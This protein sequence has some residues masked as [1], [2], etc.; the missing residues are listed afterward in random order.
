MGRDSVSRASVS[1]CLGNIF[2]AKQDLAIL[3]KSTDAAKL[4]VF[5]YK[6]TTSFVIALNFLYHKH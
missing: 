5:Y 1:E 3:L 2:S 6:E 4:R